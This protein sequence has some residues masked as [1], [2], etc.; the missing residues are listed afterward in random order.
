MFTELFRQLIE[1]PS[2]FLSDFVVVH[3]QQVC[4]K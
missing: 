2:D 4:L 1:N 3:R